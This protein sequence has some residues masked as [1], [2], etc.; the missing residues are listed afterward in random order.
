MA[1]ASIILEQR[2]AR[3]DNTFPLKISISHKTQTAY[4]PLKLY[5]AP[6]QWKES[7]NKITGITNSGRATATARRKL[8]IATD[9]I[10]DNEYRLHSFDAKELRNDIAHEIKKYEAPEDF[11]EEE[12]LINDAYFGVYVSDLI[13]RARKA[14]KHGTADW[15]QNCY[16]A[17]MKYRNDV[18]IKFSQVDK[19]FLEDFEE[20][21]LAKSSKINTISTY[22]RGLRA[23][24]NRAIADDK[25]VTTPFS[26]FKIKSEKTKKRVELFSLNFYLLFRGS[27]KILN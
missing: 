15:Y 27:L 24:F 13:E 8:A 1:T 21:H 9:Y 17:I 6:D 26:K 18:D 12:L 10:N 3:K 4:I 23:V 5:L 16:R 22:L 20:H 11:P 2:K 25:A 14:K 7:E 19:R